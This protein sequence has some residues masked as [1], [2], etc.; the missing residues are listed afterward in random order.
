[1]QIIPDVKA[2][3]HED[4]E[5]KAALEAYEA[6]YKELVGKLMADTMRPP[7]MAGLHTGHILALA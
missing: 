1:M 7:L 2:P 6:G 5:R 4:P 3:P